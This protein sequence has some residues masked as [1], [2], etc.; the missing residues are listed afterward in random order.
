MFALSGAEIVGEIALEVGMDIGAHK[1]G[2]KAS[3][4]FGRMMAD[5]R[6]H[7]TGWA[8]KQMVSLSAATER[9]RSLS[10]GPSLDAITRR[11]RNAQIFEDR[12]QKTVRLPEP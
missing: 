6:D 9:F 11:Q 7:V 1:A 5:K 12:K 10:G 8:G 2:E 4:G 3:E